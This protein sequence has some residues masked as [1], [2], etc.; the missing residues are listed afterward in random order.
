MEYKFGVLLFLVAITCFL[1]GYS[2]YS[3]YDETTEL[4][5][6]DGYWAGFAAGQQEFETYA[7][8]NGYFDLH[9]ENEEGVTYDERFIGQRYFAQEES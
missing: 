8:V 1:V 4:A 6:T 3:F 2:V 5:F 7:F 9:F